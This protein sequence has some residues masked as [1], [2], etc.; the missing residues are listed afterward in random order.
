MEWSA[1]MGSTLQ[2]HLQ[3]CSK[4]TLTMPLQLPQTGAVFVYGQPPAVAR[5]EVKQQEEVH[6]VT[7]GRR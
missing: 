2:G 1:V 4:H 5:V 3:T 7:R 6:V